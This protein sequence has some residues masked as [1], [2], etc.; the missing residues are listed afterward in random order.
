VLGGNDNDKRNQ[1]G[2]RLDRDIMPFHKLVDALP[3]K[4]SRHLAG[5][6]SSQT[7]LSPLV[8]S[9]FGGHAKR[10]CV[11]FRVLEAWFQTYYGIHWLVE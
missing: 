3:E 6:L 2:I 1:R 11:E 10:S 5:T 7:V 8:T 9:Q 4:S